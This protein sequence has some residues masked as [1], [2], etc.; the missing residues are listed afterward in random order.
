M[1]P[2]YFSKPMSH[3]HSNFAYKLL[4]LNDLD[5]GSNI[6]DFIEISFS[7]FL[8][9]CEESGFKQNF[10]NSFFKSKFLL[11]FKNPFTIGCDSSDFIVCFQT[12]TCSFRFRVYS[13]FQFSLFYVAASF[14]GLTVCCFK[15]M[16]SAQ[17]WV[18]RRGMAWDQLFVKWRNICS[19]PTISTCVTDRWTVVTRGTVCYVWDGLYRAALA[20]LLLT[21][22]IKWGNCMLQ[23]CSIKIKTCLHFMHEYDLV[24]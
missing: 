24:R 9:W 5:H 16:F 8:H 15:F 20:L 11:F 1:F 2:V 13:H 6:L 7:S 21:S 4:L 3:I 23:F 12:N 18:F 14:I 22:L 17:C 19:W 10:E